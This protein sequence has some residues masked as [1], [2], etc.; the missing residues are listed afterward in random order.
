MPDEV[1]QGH[2][3]GLVTRRFQIRSRQPLGELSEKVEVH[4]LGERAVSEMDL[5]DLPERGDVRDR[6]VKLQ[7]ESARREEFPRDMLKVSS[8]AEHDDAAPIFETIHFGDHLGEHAFGGSCQRFPLS[9]HP[10]RV[11]II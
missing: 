4:I 7:L 8:C 9:R 5:Q 6:D 1:S 10:Q 2:P 11:E 3:G